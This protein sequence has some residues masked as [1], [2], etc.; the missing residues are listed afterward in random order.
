MP[1]AP[2]SHPFLT[3]FSA[4][5][6]VCHS[7]PPYPDRAPLVS[8][9]PAI[10]HPL[11][12]DDCLPS[13]LALFIPH[14]LCSALSHHALPLRL[15]PPCLTLPL[16]TTL[17]LGNGVDR[18]WRAAFSHPLRTAFTLERNS[19]AAHHHLIDSFI[20]L[21]F[22]ISVIRSSPPPSHSVPC[23]FHAILQLRATLFASV[24]VVG[25]SIKYVLPITPRRCGVPVCGFTSGELSSAAPPAPLH[26]C[27]SWWSP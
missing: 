15:E 23:S 7:F 14:S 27:T 19:C 6:S 22:C 3:F 16:T 10:A 11:L 20:H 18:R 2:D 24:L 21:V 8:R 4:C 9:S 25:P 5:H 26:R 17:A 1:C 13:C 12:S